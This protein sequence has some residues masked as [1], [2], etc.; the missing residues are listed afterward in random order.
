MSNRTFFILFSVVVFILQLIIC[1]ALDFGPY[2]F[3]C[4]IP[5][6]VITLPR[7]RKAPAT[8]LIA[9]LLGLLLDLLSDGVPG[10]NAA[11]AV[12]V[13]F[14]RDPLYRALINRDR[15]N[16]EVFATAKTAGGKKYLA[17]LASSVGIYMLAYVILDSFGLS[18]VVLSSIKF[19]A[20][21]VA[22]TLVSFLASLAFLNKE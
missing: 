6:L 5:L 20:S 21:T 4:F 15:Q 10:L 17:Y 12:L 22:T 13:A 18:P 19:V 3:V 14:F 8:M 11:S 9:F 2:V 16:K 1:D 7:D